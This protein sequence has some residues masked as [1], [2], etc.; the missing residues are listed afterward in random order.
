M[1]YLPQFNAHNQPNIY[2]DYNPTGMTPDRCHDK[3][4]LSTK[5]ICNAI[6]KF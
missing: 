4:Y 5:I 2:T 3:H 6:L 1:I